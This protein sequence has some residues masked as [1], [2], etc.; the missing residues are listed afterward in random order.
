MSPEQLASR[1]YAIKDPMDQCL[2]AIEA[3]CALRV[4]EVFGLTWGSWQGDRLRV[5]STAWH[6]R[7]F[8]GSTKTTASRVPVCVPDGIRNYVGRWHDLCPDTL[9]EALM[10]PYTPLRGKNKGRVVPF[11]A[12]SYV[13]RRVLP[14][15]RQL[16]IASELVS[17][18]VL[19][20][21]CWH[22]ASGIRDDQGSAGSVASRGRRSMS[23]RSVPAP[24]AQS[25]SGLTL[26]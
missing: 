23:S 2:I 13:A 6:S 21:N 17:F 26:C 3:F 12:Y 1:I 14:I 4:S 25:T 16:G 15:A 5:H 8:E 24:A 18:R 19:A 22:S 20:P 11:D 9:P 7:Y 10:F